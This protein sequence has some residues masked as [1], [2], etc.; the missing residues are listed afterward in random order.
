MAIKTPGMM[1]L[2]ISKQHT[3]GTAWL[4]PHQPLS[5]LAREHADGRL[6]GLPLTAAIVHLAEFGRMLCQIP[7]RVR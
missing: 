1:V 4:Y 6:C 2:I 7:A 5:L 3:D